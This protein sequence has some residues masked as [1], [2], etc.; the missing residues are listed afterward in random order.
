MVSEEDSE[1][2]KVIGLATMSSQVFEK[3]F[4]L[5][6]RFAFKQPNARTIEDV[7]PVKST[8]AFKQPVK[9]LLKEINGA[10]PTQEL[11]DRIS[12]LIEKRHRVVHRL[13]EETGWPGNVAKEQHQHIHQ[14][15]TEVISESNFLA[16]VLANLLSEWMEKFPELRGALDNQSLGPV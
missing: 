16:S 9:A 4:V 5:A 12:A 8:T 6:A 15:C 2:Y 13:V 14:L 7:V 11:E 1:L 10:V 3:V